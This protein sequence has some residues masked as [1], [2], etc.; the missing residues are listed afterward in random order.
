MTKC[1]FPKVDGNAVQNHELATSFRDISRVGCAIE[2]LLPSLE[3]LFGEEIDYHSDS[4]FYRKVLMLYGP[5]AELIRDLRDI[6]EN[7]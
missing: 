6:Y 1:S 4:Y 5:L 2:E 3:V 7:Y